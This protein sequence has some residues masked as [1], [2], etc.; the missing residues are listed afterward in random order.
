MTISP[1]QGNEW[2]LIFAGKRIQ[3]NDWLDALL[4]YAN[5]LED[6]EQR[7]GVI[8]IWKN[9]YDVFTD[10]ETYCKDLSHIGKIMQ[11]TKSK[12]HTILTQRNAF[13]QKAADLEKAIAAIQQE[14]FEK[15]IDF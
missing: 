15:P 13:M 2:D 5:S 4:Q 12:Y 11:E 10:Y 3:M 14:K 6:R 9:L 7:S 1:L 8:N